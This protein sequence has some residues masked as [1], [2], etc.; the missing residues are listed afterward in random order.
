MLLL[1]CW[2]ILPEG[3]YDEERNKA[4]FERDLKQGKM[5]E[6]YEKALECKESWKKFANV[7]DLEK[8]VEEGKEGWIEALELLAIYYEE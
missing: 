4:L 3:N 2:E 7:E 5:R 8:I 1:N 6:V